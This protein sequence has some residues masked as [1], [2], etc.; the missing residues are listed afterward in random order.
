MNKKVMKSGLQLCVNPNAVRK[1]ADF[2]KYTATTQC[3]CWYVW[4]KGYEGEPIIR[5]I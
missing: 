1:D 4:E 3:Y 2:E 5:W